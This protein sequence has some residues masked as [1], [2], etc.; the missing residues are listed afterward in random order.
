MTS[1]IIKNELFSVA[2]T[3]KKE[4][5]QR[6]FKTGKGQYG[7]GDKFIGVVVPKIREIVKKYKSIPLNEINQLIQS[8]FHECR[9]AGLL[10]LVFMFEKSKDE[11]IRKQIYEFYIQHVDY[12]NNWDLVDLTAPNIV[13]T[14]L[15]EKNRND[16]YTFSLSNHL[17]LQRISI[18]S[19]LY[20]IRKNDLKTTFELADNLLHH[21][22][23]LIHKA[24]GWMLREAGKRDFQSEYN[25]LIE[26]KRYNSM[27]RTMLRYAVEKFPEQTRQDFLKGNI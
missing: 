14:Y 13:G 9:M 23:D 17:W 21:K 15:F 7:E 18:I 24:V 3:E 5:L 4:V 8:E 6:F 20:F 25:Y 11:N 27:P 12:I 22:H 16:L 26:N 1:E 2:D 19:T 10:F